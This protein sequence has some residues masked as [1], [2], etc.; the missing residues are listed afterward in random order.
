MKEY[1]R[2]IMKKRV[3]R[4]NHARDITYEIVFRVYFVGKI[5][6]EDHEGDI[7][8]GIVNTVYRVKPYPEDLVSLQRVNYK[9]NMRDG[10]GGAYPGTINIL[11]IMCAPFIDIYLF[12]Y[13]GILHIFSCCSLGEYSNCTG[14]I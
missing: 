11:F 12:T 1:L 2:E 13:I 14:M 7:T 10:G 4:D 8:L 6:R 3:F 5:C 9:N